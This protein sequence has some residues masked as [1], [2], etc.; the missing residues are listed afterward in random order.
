VKFL[1]F[2]GNILGE[3]YLG[4]IVAGNLREK[5]VCH[6]KKSF[7]GSMGDSHVSAVL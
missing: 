2:F 5:Y 3:K 1:G 7:D 6:Q 4:Y